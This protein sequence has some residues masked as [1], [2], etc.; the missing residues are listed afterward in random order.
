MSYQPEIDVAELQ[1]FAVDPM[2]F[3]ESLAVE[4]DGRKV[5]FGDVINPWQQ[6][7][8]R[9]LSRALRRM[10][11]LTIPPTDTELT[12]E[13]QIA[14][15]SQFALAKLRFYLERPRGHSKTTDIAL[16]VVWMM[17]FS[18]RKLTGVIA[19]ADRDQGRLIRDAVDAIVK[20]NPWLSQ[21]I[22]VQ[23]YVIRGTRFGSS[24]EVLAA[25]A[26]SCYGIT[27][28]FIVA[29]EITHWQNR[30]LWDALFSAAAKKPT[31]LVLCI[32]NAGMGK[33][34]SWQWH[35]R[36]A[37]RT[38]DDWHFHSLNGPQASWISAAALEEQKK[39]LPGPAYRRLWLNEWT[40]AAGD[41][42][43]EG[44]IAFA[45]SQKHGPMGTAQP[46]FVYGAGLDLGLSRDSAGFVVVARHIESG[47]FYLANVKTWKPSRIKRVDLE[48]VE[49]SII[50]THKLFRWS[51]M[52]ADP[53]QG[54]YLAQRL[55]KVKVP[56]DLFTLPP[57]NFD[58]L[59]R[60]LVNQ[61]SEGNVR[62]F[63]CPTLERDLRSTSVV[64]CYAGRLK[65]TWP[66]DE[67][68][69]GDTAMA[70]ALALLAAN[71]ARSLPAFSRPFAVAA[72]T[73]L[74]RTRAAQAPDGM[75]S[76]GGV[77]MSKERF[78]ELTQALVGDV[79][80]KANFDG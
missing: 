29:D 24:A 22:E 18:P 37:V 42:L 11:G 58:R 31:C 45:F 8:F 23:S 52:L 33:G 68:S 4:V 41:A 28:D 67:H 48:E 62:L 54:E 71:E 49:G 34:T 13:G 39:L 53:W 1:R 59:A 77:Q 66:R 51:K 69:H 73:Q 7:D 65:L 74:P 56:I 30:D 72:G 20:W 21:V 5:R 40:T 61:F 10:A 16:T 63:D 50:A 12:V 35:L 6:E 64:E 32:S 25:D 3:F 47:R 15:S 80:G 14:E 70:F 78:T 60:H 9:E 27:P 26:Q 36:E 76:V 75:T 38:N 17:V 44:D 19:A 43:N 79:A 46:G 2:A 57:A 55:R